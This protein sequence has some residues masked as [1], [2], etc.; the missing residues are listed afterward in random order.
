VKK[1]LFILETSGAAGQD[2][3]RALV[4]RPCFEEAQIS[5]RYLGHE[6]QHP[7][8]LAH[9]KSRVAE[10]IGRSLVY[11]AC[12][13]LTFKVIRTINRRRILRTAR[14]C[15][16][17][18]LVKVSSLELIKRIRAVS[19]ARL[20]YDLGDALWLPTFSG[21]YGQ[22]NQILATVDAV[23][24]DNR[25]GVDYA[26]QFCKDVHPW[27]A[28]PQIE[29]FDRLRRAKPSSEGKPLIIGWLGSP[30]TLYNLFEIW[31]A[32]EDLFKKHSQITLSL[33][34]AGSDPKLWPPF[35]SVRYSVCPGYTNEE[36]FNKVLDMDIGLFPMFDVENSRVRG[37][38]K[39]LVYMSGE[40]AVICSPRG[41]CPELI[42]DGQN[43]FLAESRHEWVEKLDRLVQES[44][45]RK[46]I[47]TEA[48]QRVRENYSLNRIFGDLRKVLQV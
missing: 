36:M 30:G 2:N 10:K 40:A 41:I 12:A 28:Y 34:G 6:P 47:T 20:V 15:D 18:F 8:W 24:S 29:T 21:S 35:E 14:K 22:I 44:S 11:A 5:V 39:A 9:P 26:R 31:E 3:N 42:Q 33:V 13:W 37:I 1:V 27:D 16:V 38:M 4:Y 25:Y 48:L 46:K 45:L 19:Q 43:G 32:L 7:S 17:V 23:T